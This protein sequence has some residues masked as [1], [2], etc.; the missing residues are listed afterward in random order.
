MVA[1][2]SHGPTISLA[3]QCTFTGAVQCRARFCPLEPIGFRDS[4][5]AMWTQSMSSRFGT[6]MEPN[7]LQ[8]SIRRPLN[9]YTLVGRLM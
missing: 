6:L 7:S 5:L 8:S 9:D 1:A 3:T 4:L 2:V